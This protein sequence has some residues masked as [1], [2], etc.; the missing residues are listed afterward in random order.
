M[1]SISDP[2]LLRLTPHSVIVAK[3]DNQD[4]ISSCSIRVLLYHNYRVGGG[5]VLLV[6]YTVKPR[7]LE[8][9]KSVSTQFD[10]PDSRFG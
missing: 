4:Y 7:R 5:G 8:N 10:A 2:L 6:Y 1:Q 9:S 3:K